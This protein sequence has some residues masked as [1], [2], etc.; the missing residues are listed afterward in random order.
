MRS[1]G[2]PFIVRGLGVGPV[3]LLPVC[4][5]VVCRRFSSLLVVCRRRVAVISCLWKKLQ[6]AAF[7]DVSSVASPRFLWQAWQIVTRGRVGSCV[8][9]HFAWQAQYLCDVSRRCFAFFAASAA[10][11]TGPV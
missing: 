11:W 7:F 3:C 9:S 4:R 1:E 5:V 2:F 6:E 8:E 10:F